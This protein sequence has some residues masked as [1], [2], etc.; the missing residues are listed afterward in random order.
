MLTRFYNLYKVRQALA[1][2]LAPEDAFLTN[3]RGV[4]HIGAHRG[5]ER[6]RYAAHDLDVLW[7]EADPRMFTVLSRN[8][9]GYPRQRAV[10]GLISDTDGEE[11][12][13]HVASNNGASSSML[14][15][16]G[17]A[18]EYPGVTTSDRITLRTRTFT[19]L[20]E[21]EAVDLSLYEA[22]V[23][24]VQGAELKVLAGIGDLL[25]HFRI[26]K[27]EAADYEAYAG[28]PLIDEVARYAVSEGYREVARI[29][30]GGARTERRFYDLI[31][32]REARD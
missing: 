16:K 32:E 4:V 7:I 1:R 2:P 8:L 17:H 31:F 5:P 20:V 3:V 21:E 14:P 29:P 19:R 25:S 22:L 30:F 18:E 27:L 15:M 13:F 11:V 23:V 10:Q 6:H 24:D 26:L 12:T 9:R 28:A